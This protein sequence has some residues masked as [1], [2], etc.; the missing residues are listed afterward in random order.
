PAIAQIER[1]VHGAGRMF[2]RNVQRLEVMKVVFDLRSL[3]N[4]EAGALEDALDAQPRQRDRMQSAERL[5]APRQRDV[6]RA[7]G[8][9]L[10]DRGLLQLRTARLEPLL[11]ER[12][13]RVDAG[14]GGTP[15]GLRHRAQTLQLLGERALATEPA[16][17][18]LLEGGQIGAG[19]DLSQ[20]RA[21][22]LLAVQL[23]RPRRRHGTP[24]PC[25]PRPAL[26]PR[27]ALPWLARR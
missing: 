2:G 3:G 18:H 10:P 4:L 26:P 16:H 13:R 11:D 22:E 27:A 17:A 7:G 20:R 12:F 19:R 14:A 6:D 21:Y 9:R 24:R 5:A 25:L 1:I 15:L 23:I 8:E